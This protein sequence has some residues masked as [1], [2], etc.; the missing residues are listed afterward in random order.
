MEGWREEG[1]SLSGARAS[2]SA[3]EEGLSL[4]SRHL[5]LLIFCRRSELRWAWTDLL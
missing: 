4:E 3:L 1:Y 5:A 2:G